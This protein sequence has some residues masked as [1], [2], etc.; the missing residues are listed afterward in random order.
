MRLPHKGSFLHPLAILASLGAT[1]IDSPSGIFVSNRDSRADAT[2]RACD[3]PSVF[4]GRTDS[5]PFSV[6]LANSVDCED[7]IADGSIQYADSFQTIAGSLTGFS[8]GG[9]AAASATH[10]DTLDRWKITT[11]SGQ[12][13]TELYF[14][15]VGK[16]A[17]FVFDGN[18]TGAT[19]GPETVAEV[20][21]QLHSPDIEDYL[22]RI[23]VPADSAAGPVVWHEEGELPPGYYAIS[24]SVR[25]TGVPDRASA[26]IP[27]TASASGGFSFTFSQDPDPTIVN[28]TGDAGDENPGDG[29]CD[30]GGPPV[31]GQPECTLRAAIMETN[32]TE[33][34]ARI[35]FEIPA[36]DPGYNSSVKAFRIKPKPPK[37]LPE[38][39]QPVII[40]GTT[41]AGFAPTATERTRSAS[42]AP[43]GPRPTIIL[44]GIDLGNT[45]NEFHGLNISA[46]GS[47]VRGL[48]IIQFF[49]HG[50]YL[51]E[52]GN[53]KIQGSFIGIA[54]G[55]TSFVEGGNRHDG[56]RI[57]G[58]A[59]NLIGGLPESDCNVISNNG[60][61]GT[62]GSNVLIVNAAARNNTIIGNYIGTGDK[63]RVGLANVMGVLIDKAPENA[64]VSNVISG[65]MWGIDIEG[66]ESHD[67]QVEGNLI[68]IGADGS[69]AV[70]NT[71]GG[72]LI[73]G[74]SFNTIGGP[75]AT[76]G[77]APGNVISGNRSDGRTAHGI[78][79]VT[80]GFGHNSIL[81]NLIGTDRTGSLPR[82][83]GGAGVHIELADSNDV[84]GPDPQDANV[85]ADNDSGGVVLKSNGNSVVGNFIG[86]D[87]DGNAPLGNKHWGIRVHH[88]SNNM[89]RNNLVSGNDEGGILIEGEEAGENDIVENVIGTDANQ[90]TAFGNDGP[91]IAIQGAHENRVE[92]GL[93]SGNL[94]SGVALTDSA[95]GN[96]IVDN[97]IGIDR[98]GDEALPNRADGVHI[99]D[100]PSNLMENNAVSGN[101]V[102]GVHIQGGKA[103]SN[104]LYNNQIGLSSDG[105]DSL[106][107][108]EDGVY[109]NNSPENRIE[110]N[111]IGANGRY[112]VFV[113]GGA[114][115]SVLF[116]NI[117]GM[118]SDQSK[119]I[120]NSADGIRSQLNEKTVIQQNVIA[121]NGFNGIC[122]SNHGTVTN[123]TVWLNTIFSNGQNGVLVTGG[124]RNVIRKN[125]IYQNGLLGIDLEPVGVTTN[126]ETDGDTGPNDL[127]NYPVLRIAFEDTFSLTTTLIGYLNSTPGATFDIDLFDNIDCDAT[128]RG[129]GRIY[130]ETFQVTTGMDGVGGFSKK[131]DYLLVNTYKAPGGQDKKS[132]CNQKSS[133][134][135]R[136]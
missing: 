80:A 75:T 3:H 100:S 77:T 7:G 62:G 116:K 109:L 17:R 130:L 49:G 89:I 57:E 86:T 41:Q 14:Q 98:R 66:E 65:N 16:P 52:K 40:D 4:D 37:A 117:I 18:A 38:I 28:S 58:I 93:V 35:I 29:L 68:G 118:N 25:A 27:H 59:D 84:G 60:L 120:G 39:T 102:A 42:S 132:S 94:G 108:G 69:L 88:K 2:A 45:S 11:G 87:I 127:Q 121:A 95:W 5:L 106:G 30:T 63:G 122:I 33:G 126:D 9:S 10:L 23:F 53:N 124:T 79:I 128:G 8:G 105:L 1:P 12:G 125:S 6:N 85:I 54:P 113:L 51:H 55:A 73:N 90:A 36:S 44:D 72:I 119:R 112:G 136:S 104:V 43:T 34:I 134:N 47:E 133:C 24:T 56:I 71:F 129:E 67:N 15:V 64:V 19:T 81:G 61:S 135:H 92:G 123:D 76:P 96:T 26:N 78:S 82:G 46:G 74:A 13:L 22:W 111:V 32:A 103:R 115:S 110:E 91:G 99:L 31:N 107:N 70:P 21:V 101:G 50:I 131:L 20:S 83:N 97:L 48:S 114:T